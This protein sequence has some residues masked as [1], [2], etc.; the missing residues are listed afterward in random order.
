MY[1]DSKEYLNFLLENNIIISKEPFKQYE[2]LNEDV[3]NRNQDWEKIA[4]DYKNNR[5]VIVDNF[6]YPEYA[7]RLQDFFLFFNAREDIYSDYAALNFYKDNPARI[8]F[9]LLTSITEECKILMPF[10]DG[11]NFERAWA[12]IYNNISNGVPAHADPAATNL[13][14]WVTPDESMNIAEGYNGLD[15]WKVYP[16]E[17]WSHA[18]YNGDAVLINSFLQQ[19]PSERVNIPYKFN[20]ITIFDSKLFH[21]TQPVSS[22]P[23]YKNRRINYTFLY[24]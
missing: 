20:R 8:W 12:F 3:I 6:L 4:E 15:V 7:K 17:E 10:L 21:K 23:G 14:L 18:Q 1:N 22:K 13:N 9:P 11:L 2:K 24:K 5:V 16:P 19:H